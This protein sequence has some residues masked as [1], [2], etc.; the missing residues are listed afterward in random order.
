MSGT[1]TEHERALTSTRCDGMHVHALPT[2][3]LKKKFAESAESAESAGSA[4]SAES[5]PASWFSMVND[6]I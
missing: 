3:Q 2:S 1:R 6:K 4:E 5:R